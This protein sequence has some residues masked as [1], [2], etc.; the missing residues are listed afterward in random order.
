MLVCLFLKLKN[1]KNVLELSRIIQ[2]LHLPIAFTTD[3]SF[4]KLKF[5]SF[6]IVQIFEIDPTTDREALDNSNIEN[7]GAVPQCYHT[8]T[9]YGSLC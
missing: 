1:Q 3:H 6:S 4:A 5:G 9:V 8:A 2:L 7:Q